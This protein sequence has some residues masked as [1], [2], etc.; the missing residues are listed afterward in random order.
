MEECHD[1]FRIAVTQD[2]ARQLIDQELVTFF[3][4]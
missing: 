3:S 2:H 4:E 1:Y